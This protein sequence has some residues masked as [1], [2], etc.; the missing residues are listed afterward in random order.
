MQLNELTKTAERQSQVGEQLNRYGHLTDQLE[1]CCHSFADRLSRVMTN[2]GMGLKGPPRPYDTTAP[3]PERS[4]LCP[5][6]EELLSRN[7]SL[8]VMIDML[9][10]MYRR[11]EI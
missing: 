2:D 7:N 11:I 4:P 6:A 5:M 8:E 3:T 9:N 1:K 10:S